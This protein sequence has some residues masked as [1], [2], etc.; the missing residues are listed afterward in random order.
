MS[1]NYSHLLIPD[2]IAF[3]PQPAQVT[4]FLEGLLKLGSAPLDATIQISKLSGKVRTGRNAFTGEIITI[5]ARELVTLADLD[6][7]SSG[8]DGLN[9][10]ILFF[11]GKGPTEQQPFKLYLPSDRKWQ[12]D[13]R[14]EHF[15]EVA[16]NLRASAVLLTEE[17]LSRPCTIQG[18]EGIFQNPWNNEVIKVSNAACARFWME[19]KFGNWLV[20]K[21][22]KSLDLLSSPILKLAN[23]CFGTG[24]A[25]G[26][27]FG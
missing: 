2:S 19:F 25:Q 23:N 4:A 6:A 17:S 5:P 10:Y 24:F 27:S 13:F 11:S 9:D 8:L 22:D 1:E 21:I 26:C 20:P 12:S 15:Y 18:G 3:A 16:F 7:I 14:N